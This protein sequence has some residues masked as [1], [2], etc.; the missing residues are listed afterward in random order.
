M[1]DLHCHLLP[2]VDDGAVSIEVARAMLRQA[3]ADGIDTIVVTPHALSALCRDKDLEALRSSW[4]H[5]RPQLR[6]GDHASGP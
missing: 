1:I 6:Q 4:E 2:G 3:E 5:W